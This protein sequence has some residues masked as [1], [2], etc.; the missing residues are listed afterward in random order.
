MGNS[1]VL[2]HLSAVVIALV[3]SLQLV[4]ISLVQAVRITAKAVFLMTR[5]WRYNL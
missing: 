5:V 1:L 2:Q 4:V 3:K